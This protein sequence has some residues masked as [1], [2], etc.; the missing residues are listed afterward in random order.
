MRRMSTGPSDEAVAAE[1]E[2]DRL[3]ELVRARYGDR[4]SAEQLAEVRQG[5]AGIVEAV[6]ELRRVRLGNADEP[7]QPFA[8]F[9]ATS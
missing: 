3:F 4:L 7:A 5:V 8:V 6:Q 9:R 1:V 2:I